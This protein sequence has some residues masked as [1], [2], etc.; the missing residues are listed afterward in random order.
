MRYLLFVVF[1]LALLASGSSKA[2]VRF[3]SLETVVEGN[4][5]DDPQS[6]L[7]AC[8]FGYAQSTPMT[9]RESTRGSRRL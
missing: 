5:R 1:W 2:W 6:V 9:Q 4:T 3:A 7:G 8:E